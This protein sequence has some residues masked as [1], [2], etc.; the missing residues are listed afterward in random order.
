MF[1]LTPLY[2]RLGALTACGVAATVIAAPIA[3]ANWG[4]T[5]GG[6]Q[7][8][9]LITEHSLGQN[10]PASNALRCRRLDPWAYRLVCAGA[11]SNVSATRNASSPTSIGSAASQ[12]VKSTRFD[13]GA[14]SIGA[15]TSL[16]LVLLVVG[17]G[18]FALRR[19]R[20]VAHVSS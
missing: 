9:P 8:V 7:P 14:A 13:W 5:A 17:G 11:G 10:R 16:G 15:A 12:A 1:A 6:Q 19:R 20:T 18:T 3:H 2:R 4:S